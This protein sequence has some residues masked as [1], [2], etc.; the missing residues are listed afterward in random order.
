MGGLSSALNTSANALSTFE[1]VFEVIGN[2]I[3]NANTPG[4][5]RQ[6]QSIKS[7]PFDPA[8]GVP[9]GVAAGPLLNSRSEYLEQALR[10]QQTALGGA[11][12]RAGDLSQIQ[13]LFSLTAAT[14][15]ANSLNSFF[16]TF[17]QLTVNPNDEISRQAVITQAGQLAQSIHQ[18]AVGIEQVSAN[19]TSQTGVVVTQ[20]NQFASQIA[21]INQ[22][23]RANTQAQQDENLDTDLHNA[24]GNLAGLANVSVIRASDGS[25]NVYLGGQVPL[26][27]G[28]RV[29]P[30]SVGKSGA[31]TTILD[32]SGN[33]ITSKIDGGQLGA[34]LQE[35]NS[36]LPSYT[37]DLNTLAQSLADKVN[38]TLAAGVDKNGATPAVNLFSYNGASAASTIAVTG[39]TPDQIAAASAGSP[40]GNGNAVALSQLATAPVI[41]GFTFTQFYGNLGSRVGSD[42]ANAQQDQ[43]QAQDQLTQAQAQRTKISGV[44][45]NEEATALLQFQ[46]A[47]QAVG[48]LVGVLNTL[49]STVMNMLQPTA[50]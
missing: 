39:I 23:Y 48:K 30:I 40:S 11:Q 38:A 9:G 14:G 19:I 8:H 15:I 25:F 3:A 5:A 49:S 13:P 4:Y 10:I 43:S 42:V 41:N 50:G 34:L 46:Q 26:V 32:A 29:A 33:D 28:D 2:N 36:T 31:S 18:S 7:L 35:N 16:N 45:L 44:D 17:S 6:I 20:I 12:Q 24:L 1:R 47:Y 21:S 37:T 27:L 22:R